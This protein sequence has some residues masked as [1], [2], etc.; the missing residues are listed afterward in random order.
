VD[1]GSS[2]DP[3]SNNFALAAFNDDSSGNATIFGANFS[4]T[5]GRLLDLRAGNVS[6][7]TVEIDGSAT[8]KEAVTNGTFN[9]TSNGTFGCQLDVNG[10]V[11]SQRLQS[12][13]TTDILFRGLNGA[14]TTFSVLKDGSATFAGTVTANGNVLTRNVVLNLEADDDTKY[15]ATTNEDGEQTLVYNGAVLDVKERIQNV[16]S[17]MDAIEANEVTDDATD[18]ALLTLVASLS[19]RLDER[20]ATIAA[21]TTRITTLEIQSNGGN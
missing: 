12:A 17:R 21:L 2:T 3:I 8:F 11:Q 6:K 15:T 7:A 18:S 19:S 13:P 10:T 16:I 20:D 1:L 14:T 9:P 5:T 4:S